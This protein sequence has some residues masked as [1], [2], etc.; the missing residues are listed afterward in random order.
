LDEKRLPL[1]IANS[2]FGLL[3]SK[4]LFTEKR[5]LLGKEDLAAQEQR[6]DGE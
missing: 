1:C 2:T 5:W 4:T 6:R 3:V